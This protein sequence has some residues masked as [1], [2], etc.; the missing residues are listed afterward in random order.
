ML[1]QPPRPTLFPYTTLFRSY[2][3]WRIVRAD[4]HATHPQH[5]FAGERKRPGPDQLGW[6]RRRECAGSDRHVS[7]WLVAEF[8]G[9]QLLADHL[10]RPAGRLVVARDWSRHA[11]RQEQP[12]DGWINNVE[13]NHPRGRH[14]DLER[15]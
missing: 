10:R 7:R 8:F 2:P 4:R 5:G 14:D 13:G 11:R 12:D 6:N 3:G 15:K 9:S 1:W